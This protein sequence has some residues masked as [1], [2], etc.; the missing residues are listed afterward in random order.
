M[1]R[2]D[3]DDVIEHVKVADRLAV[4]GA[5]ELGLVD[6]HVPVDLHAK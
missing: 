4:E 6:D 3:L 2:K 1:L 5:L